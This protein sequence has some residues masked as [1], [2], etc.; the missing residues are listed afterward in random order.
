MGVGESTLRRWIARARKGQTLVQKRGRARHGQPGPELTARV[1]D[2]VR[3]LR[4]LVGAESLRRSVVG[5]SRRQA[6]AI[7]RDTLIAMERERVEAA[8]R[9]TITA[10]GI[11]R[12]FDAMHVATTA[13]Q[14]LK[15]GKAGFVAGHRLSV[16]QAGG[17][18]KR[19]QCLDYEREAFGPVVPIAGE[20]PHPRGAPT[21]QEPEAIMFDF[22]NPIAA[23]RWPLNGARQAR[24]DKVGEDRKRHNMP[25]YMR[26]G[27]GWSRIEIPTG[28]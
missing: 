14:T 5:I 15:F 21:R 23:G 11:V 17:D 18:F 7:K 6:A 3:S 16:D 25:Y 13:A 1:A 26:Y 9:I 8:E 22:M 10:P 28:A 27:T 20:K 4:G 12:G 19:A 2:V 24:L